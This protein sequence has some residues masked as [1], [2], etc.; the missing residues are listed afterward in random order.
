MNHNNHYPNYEII[1][2]ATGS[3]LMILGAVCGASI[4]F[5]CCFCSSSSTT[6]FSDRLL[7]LRFRRRRPRHRCRNKQQISAS[8]AHVDGANDNCDGLFFDDGMLSSYLE[9]DEIINNKEEK[10]EFG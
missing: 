4:M 10:I 5:C 9:E 1:L 2:I 6:E 3:V 8:S 7:S